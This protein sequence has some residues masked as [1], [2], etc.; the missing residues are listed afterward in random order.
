MEEKNF[1]SRERQHNISANRHNQLSTV[2]E[3]LFADAL[4][5]IKAEAEEKARAYTLTISRIRAEATE[6]I[7][8]VK[9]EAEA[10]TKI[11]TETIARIMANA[12]EK[13]QAH[14]DTTGK[15]GHSATVEDFIS[16]TVVNQQARPSYTGPADEPSDVIEGIFSDTLENQQ[17]RPSYTAPAEEPLDA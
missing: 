11:Y 4:A 7:A 12:Q 10:R 8:N 5:K 2:V 14:T 1:L 17:V 13:A 9:A 6:T 16:G 15:D 3:R